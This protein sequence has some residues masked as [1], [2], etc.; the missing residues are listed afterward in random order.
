MRPDIETR[1]LETAGALM[2]RGAAGQHVVSL[3]PAS[4]FAQKKVGVMG[5]LADVVHYDR[6]A[7]FTGVVDDDVTEAHYSLWNR[8]RDSDVLDFAQR[9]VFRSPSDEARVDLKLRI[10]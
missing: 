7:Q 3:M 4:E 9:D 10:G 1:S 8:G 6:A 2:F 5:R